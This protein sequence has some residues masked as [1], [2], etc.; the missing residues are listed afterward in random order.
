M[1][2]EI[3]NVILLD[4]S[5]LF[6]SIMRSSLFSKL[7]KNGRGKFFDIIKA[8]TLRSIEEEDIIESKLSNTFCCKALRVQRQKNTKKFS[9][10]KKSI[11]HLL[12]LRCL[13]LTI[14]K[15]LMC[16]AFFTLKNVVSELQESQNIL[17]T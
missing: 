16:R 13:L 11:F 10:C 17:N 2:I 3:C 1:I 7:L 15:E 9:T 5:A 8:D 4:Y 14:G 12:A 6:L